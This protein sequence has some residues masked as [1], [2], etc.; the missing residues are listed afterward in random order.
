ML[1]SAPRS[2]ECPDCARRLRQSI[3][4]FERLLRD[5]VSAEVADVYRAEI[6]AAKAML[7]EI[8][9]KP[10]GKGPLKPDSD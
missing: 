1:F 3:A 6:A 10:Q 9:R 5:G 7:K 8:E 4:H 2:P